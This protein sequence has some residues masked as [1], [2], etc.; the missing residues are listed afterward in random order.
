MKI[1][2]QIAK[3]PVWS[4]GFTLSRILLYSFESIPLILGRRI[5]GVSRKPDPPPPSNH[6]QI[7]NLEIFNMLKEDFKNTNQKI[8][9]TDTFM[10]DEPIAHA[11]RYLKI[12]NDAMKSGLRAKKKDYKN[13][14][15]AAQQHLAGLPEYYA[16]NFH[17]QTDGY[18]SRDS[19][20]LY[21]HQTEILFM[22][23]LSLMRR[24]LLADIIRVAQKK[25]D[26]FHVLEIGAG[27]GEA[28]EILARSVPKISIDAIDL[29]EPYLEK[30]KERLA[31]LANN[32][33]I[34]AD[35]A[36]YQTDVK[37]DAVVST[38]C[39]H[40]MPLDVRKQIVLN[41]SRHLKKGGYL[42]LVDSL[43]LGDRPEFDWALKQFPKDFHE[44][45]YKNYVKT[46]LRT[47]LN[48]DFE[49]VEEK[50]RFLSKALLARKN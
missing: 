35:G 33:F 28:T 40:E 2:F 41:A 4:S 30:A 22:G 14:S 37:Y 12:L 24:L 39:L 47:L 42:L 17:Y 20:E 44:P 50:T 46:P 25:S 45:F 19:A 34:K 15:P 9:S 6:R 29:S 36:N 23:T 49:L 1:P 43:Q 8:Y 31:G 3:Q 10:S 48:A 21:D 11:K 26:G 13:F 7:L 5:L 18:L 38:Y 32:Q 27:A 16:R